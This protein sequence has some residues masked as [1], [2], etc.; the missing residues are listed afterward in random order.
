MLFIIPIFYYTYV[1][2]LMLLFKSRAYSLWWTLCL[3]CST[4]LVSRVWGQFLPAH[5]LHCLEH[6]PTFIRQLMT[7]K[8]ISCKFL[9]V[10]QTSRIIEMKLRYISFREYAE[11][12]KNKIKI[13][14]YRD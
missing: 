2:F 5:V 13:G 7:Q 9:H 10:W 1:I 12:T 6:I 4:K 3:F 11:T 14:D 8:N